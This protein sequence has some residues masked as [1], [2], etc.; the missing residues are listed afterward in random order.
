MSIILN[1]FFWE[2]IDP[3]LARP[4]AVLGK[5]GVVD[6]S[7]IKSEDVGYVIAHNCCFKY[8]NNW[9]ILFRVMDCRYA[10]V[11]I[12]IKDFMKGRKDIP[13]P[14]I[15]FKRSHCVVDNDLDHIVRYGLTDEARRVL[16]LN[17]D[18][19]SISSEETFIIKRKTLNSLNPI[20]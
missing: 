14:Y 10:Y 2:Y 9:H 13:F 19:E 12:I 20:V 3:I 17:Y 6:C 18:V 1:D 15:N 7:P 11:Q 16:D 5:S 8:L 4:G